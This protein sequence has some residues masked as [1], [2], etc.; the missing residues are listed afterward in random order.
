MTMPKVAFVLHASDNVATVIGG[1]IEAGEIVALRGSMDMSVVVTDSIPDGHKF[2]LEDI[3]AGGTILK[4]GS[5]VGRANVAVRKGEH[6]HVHN[7]ESLRGRGDLT[8]C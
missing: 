8:G 3:D 2:A 4:Y 6:V 7:M 1:G 5:V